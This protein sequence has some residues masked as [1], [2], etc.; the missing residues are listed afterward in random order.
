MVVIVG[1][2][3]VFSKGHFL[4]RFPESSII[5]IFYSLISFNNHEG[6]DTK[7]GIYSYLRKH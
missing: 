1:F 4:L 6:T 2:V 7:V 5:D 3:K